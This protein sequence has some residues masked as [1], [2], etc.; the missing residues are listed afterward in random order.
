M[1]SEKFEFTKDNINDVLKDI[2]KE[3]HK[4]NKYGPEAEIIIVGGASALLNYNFRST[5]IDID[6]LIFANSTFKEAVNKVGD[7]YNL[8]NGWLNADFKYT[9]SYSDK[10]IEHSK[11]YKSFYNSL[12][13][14]TVSGEYMIAMKLVSDRIY[15]KDYS[16]IIGII[17]DER[18]KGNNISFEDIDNAVVELYGNWDKISDEAKSF[19]LVALDSKDLDSLYNDTEKD[20]QLNKNAL[21]D[22]NERYSDVITDDNAKDFIKHFRSFISESDDIETTENYSNNVVYEELE[23]YD[24]Y[25]DYDPVD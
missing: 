22:A 23:D 9:E 1:S 19:L 14:R 25:D 8:P 11:Y 6:A 7:K 18:N 5:T 17:R 2:G 4:L 24:D 21:L 12:T 10:L 13:I 20:E 3:Y 16:D 15:K